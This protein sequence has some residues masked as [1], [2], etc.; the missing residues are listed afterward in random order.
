MTEVSLSNP[1]PSMS[2]VPPV[3]YSISTPIFEFLK[4]LDLG[5]V[6]L[7]PRIIPSANPITGWELVEYKP[8]KIEKESVASVECER[9]LGER[10]S[11]ERTIPTPIFTVDSDEDDDE[12]IIQFK[13]TATPSPQPTLKP[14]FERQKKTTTTPIVPFNTLIYQ[15]RTR[16]SGP[17]S[18]FTLPEDIIEI[19]VLQKKTARE[20]AG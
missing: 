4:S 14:G 12:P 11:T 16:S 13:R 1:T 9:D 17:A 20:A 2:I 3:S 19:P 6:A 15:C 18:V 5:F 8:A 10:M 7:N